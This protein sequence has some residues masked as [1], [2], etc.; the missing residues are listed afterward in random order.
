MASPDLADRP[1]RELKRTGRGMQTLRESGLISI[2][3]SQTTIDEV[4]RETITED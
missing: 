2:Y 4:V 3:D 1:P